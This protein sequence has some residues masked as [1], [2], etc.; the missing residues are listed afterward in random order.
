MSAS[1]TAAFWCALC[2][3]VVVVASAA[4]EPLLGAAV[5]TILLIWLS[6]VVGGTEMLMFLGTMLITASAS[7]PAIP[8]SGQLAYLV[9][10]AG[11]GCWICAGLARSGP[12]LPPRTPHS[13]FAGLV[14]AGLS[15]YGLVATWVAGQYTNFAVVMVSVGVLWLCLV[16]TSVWVPAES[17]RRGLLAGLVVFVAASLILGLL[18]P[19]VGI[20]Q[21]RLRGVAENA[22]GLGCYAFVLGSVVVTSVRNRAMVAGLLAMCLVTIA[23]TGSRNSALALAV[24][25]LTLALATA[26]WP[27]RMAGLLVAAAV[28]LAALVLRSDLATVTEWL[29]ARG[30]SRAESFDYAVAVV[31]QR[32]WTGVG[33]GREAVEVASSP[34]RALVNAGIWGG[35]GVVLAWLGILI[36][37]LRSG[38]RT[39]AV[40]LG[41]ITFSLAEGVLLSPLGSFLLVLLVALVV[42]QGAETG[43]RSRLAGRPAGGRGEDGSAGLPGNLVQ[44][45]SEQP[46]LMRITDPPRDRSGH[47]GHGDGRRSGDRAVGHTRGDHAGRPDHRDTDAETERRVSGQ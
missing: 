22:N 16:S 31:S 9:R 23:W 47:R 15:L 41:I 11:V 5:A 20:E 13:T 19:S 25:L 34:L 38:V 37:G 4:A 21:G 1:R 46:D 36:Y 6:V 12:R 26:G 3:V 39:T 44:P 32:T 17:A 33:L 2:L 30:N 43:N 29:L 24:V 35:V 8:V 18:W 7:G 45:R 28:G 14:V 27:S 40:A 10:L 42:V